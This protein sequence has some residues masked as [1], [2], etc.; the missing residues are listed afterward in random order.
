[1]LALALGVLGGCGS[2]S[3]Y[4]WGVYEPCIH[5]FC[6]GTDD[7]SLGEQIDTLTRD[8]N[9]IRRSGRKVPPGMFAH[10]AYVCYL[11]GDPATAAEYLRAEKEAFPESARFV[12][13]MMERIR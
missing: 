3:I 4:R 5:A 2:P 10:L 12:T 6:E 7:E 1:M 13:I 11:N 8:V 9:K